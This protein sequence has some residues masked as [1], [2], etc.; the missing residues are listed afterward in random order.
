MGRVYWVWVEGSGVKKGW[1][2]RDNE[3]GLGGM[4]FVCVSENCVCIVCDWCV[5]VASTKV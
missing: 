2:A 1:V 5:P 4:G 3:V